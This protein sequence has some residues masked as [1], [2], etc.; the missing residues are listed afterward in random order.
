M[1]LRFLKYLLKNTKFKKTSNGLVS[2]GEIYSVD[3]LPDN[4]IQQV[5][6]V[7]ES[8]TNYD[9][10]NQELKEQLKDLHKQ[11]RDL[12]QQLKLANPQDKKNSISI[13]NNFFIVDFQI[14]LLLRMI[15]TLEVNENITS[16]D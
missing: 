9:N 13:N 3:S 2:G 15:L 6:Q 7:R 16:T 11:R 10:K 12:N 8:Q 14:K 4:F 1:N 5:S